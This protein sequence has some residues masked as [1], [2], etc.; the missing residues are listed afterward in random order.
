MEIK[1]PDNIYSEERINGSCTVVYKHKQ[2]KPVSCSK[3]MIRVKPRS[4]NAG[5][6]NVTELTARDWL[7]SG[8]KRDFTILC[9]KSNASIDLQCILSD[10]HMIKKIKGKHTA[11]CI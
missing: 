2:H 10:S 3:M 5:T 9:S 7:A 4:P 8:C 6:C 11:L 1:I